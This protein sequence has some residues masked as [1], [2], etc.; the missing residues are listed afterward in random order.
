MVLSYIL[1]QRHYPIPYN[2]KKFFLYLGI[3]LGIYFFAC[4]FQ[5][6]DQVINLVYRNS[7]LLMLIL[8]LFWNEKK[9]L[10]ELEV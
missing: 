6:E 2:L 5:F 1:G 8:F 10:A 7:L 9:P 3:T 4:E